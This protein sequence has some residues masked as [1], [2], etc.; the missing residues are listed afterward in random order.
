MEAEEKALKFIQQHEKAT[1]TILVALFMAC[2]MFVSF[3]F[4][5]ALVC[6]QFDGLIDMSFKCHAGYLNQTP[7]VI[8]YTVY[9]PILTEN[10]T[11]FIN[12]R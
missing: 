11:V 6:S 7:T 4:G 1:I 2:I 10:Y 5:G 3:G 9:K 12:G 8:N